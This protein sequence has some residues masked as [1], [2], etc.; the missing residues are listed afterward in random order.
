ML[1]FV[2]IVR[3]PV[4]CQT[5]AGA[6][7]PLRAHA[8]ACASDEE[9]FENRADGNCLFDS[10]AQIWLRASY[11]PKD[12]SHL[13]AEDAKAIMKARSTDIP[14]ISNRIRQAVCNLLE[15]VVLSGG[16]V[17]AELDTSGE[18]GPSLANMMRQDNLVHA[19]Y[20]MRMRQERCWGTDLE[21]MAFRVL[22]GMVVGSDTADNISLQPAGAVAY[23]RFFIC[24]LKD[25]PDEADHFRLK[26]YD[27]EL[28]PVTLFTGPEARVAAYL[29]KLKL[30]VRVSLMA[31]LHAGGSAAASSAA[32]PAPRD[33]PRPTATSPSASADSD[34]VTAPEPSLKTKRA[35][36]LKRFQQN[37]A[38]MHRDTGA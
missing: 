8:M 22:T 27:G 25:R 28:P 33:A 29:R 4:V 3:T 11:R 9:Y 38:E 13:K 24:N 2:V 30:R 20:V 17:P 32:T 15:I 7:L 6:C 1:A 21:L 14:N 18:F 23:P 36:A 16:V 26:K 12:V 10:L 37:M 35:N 31:N 5:K 34:S 19:D